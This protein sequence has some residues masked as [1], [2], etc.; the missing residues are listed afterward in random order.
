MSA[1]EG[2][3]TVD[4]VSGDYLFFRDGGFY[5]F[6]GET[7]DERPS[8][9]PFATDGSDGTVAASIDTYGVVL[10]LRWPEQVWLYRH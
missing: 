10:V 1:R 3:I 5:T 9:P 7:W 6:D 4:P 8:A 2:L